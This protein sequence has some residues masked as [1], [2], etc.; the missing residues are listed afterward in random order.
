MLLNSSAS[1]LSLGILAASIGRAPSPA[2]INQS[3]RPGGRLG[4]VT[5]PFFY[6]LLLSEYEVPAA[7]LLP[8]LFVAL[9]AE[10]L[11]L[12]IA[13]HT[14]AVSGYAGLHHRLLGRIRAI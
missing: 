1:A 7:I 4:R 2:T 11:F 5:H 6:L 8:A 3:D 13:D 9:R 14:D 12:A 10:R